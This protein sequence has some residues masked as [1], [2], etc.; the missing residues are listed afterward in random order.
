VFRR[1]LPD[2]LARVRAALGARDLNDLAEAAHKIVGTLGAFSTI[3]GAVA[4]TIEDA[5]RRE[6]FDS[7]ASLVGQLESMCA[8]VLEDTRGLTL[9]ALSL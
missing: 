6:D 1:A 4:S 8:E 3:A 2:H 5:A 7:C 9:D